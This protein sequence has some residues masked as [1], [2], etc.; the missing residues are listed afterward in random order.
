M[1]SSL[2]IPYLLQTLKDKHGIILSVTQ[3]R[4]YFKQELGMSYSKLGIVGKHYDDH[5]NL[6]KRQLAAADY[7][8]L[9]KSGREIIN[10]DENI[11]R[12]TDHRTRGCVRQ[13]K[14][15]LTSHALR[16]PQI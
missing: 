1:S 14:R 12:S 6:L 8:R 10:V 5:K 9:L 7:I 4:K 3:L 11:I 13:G 2:Q 15:I 16:L